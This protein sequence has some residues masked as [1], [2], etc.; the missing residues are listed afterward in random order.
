MV[1]T[2]NM[3]MILEISTLFPDSYDYITYPKPL[4]PTLHAHTYNPASIT[5]LQNIARNVTYVAPYCTIN[6][7]QNN[8]SLSTTSTL[9]NFGRQLKNGLAAKG[10]TTHL[11]CSNSHGIS[12]PFVSL[13]TCVRR[14]Q[15]TKLHLG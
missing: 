6:V 4:P 5:L 14:G 15:P 12:F 7:R 10:L 13:M 11:I 9:C 1:G 2:D 8:K 3:F